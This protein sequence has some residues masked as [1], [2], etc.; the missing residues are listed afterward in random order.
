MNDYRTG[1][2]GTIR[3]KLS[4]VIVKMA[5]RLLTNYGLCFCTGPFG[6]NGVHRKDY[7]LHC[8]VALVLALYGLDSVFG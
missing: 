5:I 3:R 1:F 6:P 8:T 4:L 7:R 2:L